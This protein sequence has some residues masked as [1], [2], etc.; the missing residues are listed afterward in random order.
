MD[1]WLGRF[2]EHLLMRRLQTFGFEKSLYERP[3]QK[4]IC[5]RAGD[6]HCCL[7]GPDAQGKCTATT[8]CRPLRKGDRWYCTRASFL[9][10]PCPEGPLP[11]GEC[12]RTIPKCSPVRSLRSWRGLVVVLSVAVTLAGLL[13]SIADPRAKQILSP[14]EVSFA[15]RSVGDCSKCHGGVA[16]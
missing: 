6:G 14:G 8:E 10:G 3:N 1:F 2:H 9:G 4:W 11:G 12:C 15:H 16:G 5:G 13:L 7:A